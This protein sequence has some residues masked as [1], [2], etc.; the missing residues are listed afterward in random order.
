MAGVPV[1]TP[2]T[3]AVR[4]AA[5]ERN[6]AATSVTLAAYRAEPAAV[7]VLA[8][9]SSAADAC[10]GGFALTV[11]GENQQITEITRELAP[12]GTDEAIA[13]GLTAEQNGKKVQMKVIMFRKGA[14]VGYL[15]TTAADA[16][17]NDFAAFADVSRAQ[18]LK[19][20]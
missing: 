8:D 17:A 15:G 1:E 3:T 4:R 9:L 16:T 13:F 5:A 12:A 14:T 18:L 20:G 11:K 7:A 2:V 19:L 10:A 6:G